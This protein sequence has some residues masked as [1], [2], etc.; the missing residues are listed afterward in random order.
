M[1]RGFALVS[2]NDQDPEIEVDALKKA[3]AEQA[4]R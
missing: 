2:T 1:I 4:F 3:R